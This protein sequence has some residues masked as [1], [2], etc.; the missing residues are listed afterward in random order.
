[1]QQ[2]CVPMLALIALVL[3]AGCSSA[4]TSAVTGTPTAPAGT[5][6]PT[7]TSTTPPSPTITPLPGTVA[8]SDAAIASQLSFAFVRANDVWVSLRGATPRQVTHLG[9]PAQQLDWRLIWSADQTRLLATESNDFSTGAFQG[10]SWIIGLPDQAVT[11]LSATDLLTEGCTISCGWLGDRYLVHADVA[12]VGSHAQVYHVFDTHTRRDLSTRLDSEVITAWEVRGASLYF[13]PYLDSTGRGTFAPGAILRF[14]LASN[15][16]TTVF[17]VTIGAL[18][19]EGISAANWDISADGSKIVYYFFGGALHDCPA[20]V[21]CETMYQDS[22]GRVTAIFLHYQAGAN[23]TIQ[24]NMPIWISPDGKIA[25]GFITGGGASGASGPLD[26]LVQQALPSG[27][28]WSNAIAPGDHPHDDRVLGWMSQPAGIIIQRI[29]QDA[30][31]NPL[32]AAI[33]FAPSGA[34]AAA[35]LVA[36]VQAGQVVFA[37]PV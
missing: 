2:R 25:A 10:Q 7:A 35:H 16:I 14:D 27:N 36:T 1:M 15:Q 3:L 21:H 12:K 18:V 4:N 26:T 20:G 22:T 29:E 37:P 6:L 11:P 8:I 30:Q 23:L 24:I 9:L 31:G 33:L 5:S 32:T 34:D 28:A 19:S 13:S 17:T